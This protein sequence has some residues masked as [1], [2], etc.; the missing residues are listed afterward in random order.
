MIPSDGNTPMSEEMEDHKTLASRLLNKIKLIK[1]RN[2]VAKGESHDIGW[3]LSTVHDYWQ[4]KAN[5]DDNSPSKYADYN[6]TTQRRAEYL[7]QIINQLGLCGDDAILELGTNVGVVFSYLYDKGYHNLTG[8]EINPSAVAL[9]KTTFPTMYANSKII[10]GTFEETLPVCSDNTYSVVYSIAVLMHVHPSSNFIFQH[11][12]RIAKNYIVTIEGE[13]VISP[14]HF[15]RNYKD[16]FEKLGFKQVFFEMTEGK[17]P[18]YPNLHCR[19]FA[20]V[21]SS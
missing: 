2:K 12:A 15:P 21:P 3:S 6:V 16:I 9:M 13:N 10:T 14:K 18:N 20:K 19:V 11:I 5:Y 1:A 8:I 4:E 7:Y 17:I